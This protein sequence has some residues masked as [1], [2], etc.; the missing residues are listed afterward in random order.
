MLHYLKTLPFMIIL[1]TAS[2]SCEQSMNFTLIS[3]HDS[4]VGAIYG[5]MIKQVSRLKFIDSTMPS[6]KNEYKS[7]FANEDNQFIIF[8]IRNIQSIKSELPLIQYVSSLTNMGFTLGL[9][10]P[11]DRAC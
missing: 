5:K 8:E 4:I 6:I 11:I 1:V 3:D 9:I 10:E 7:L 2:Y